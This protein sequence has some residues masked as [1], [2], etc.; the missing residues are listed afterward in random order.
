MF[1]EAAPSVAVDAAPALASER[2][3]ADQLLDPRWHR[4]PDRLADRGGHV[5]SDEIQQRQGP[6]RVPGSEAHAG[7]DV[8]GIH[9]GLFEQAHGAEQIR[10]EQPI[11]DEAGDVGDLDGCLLE[12]LAQR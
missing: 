3:F 12:V 5:E 9:G 1:D 11:D 6:H 8:L 10:E 7:V 2:A 4:L